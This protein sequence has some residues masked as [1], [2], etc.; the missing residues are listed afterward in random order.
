MTAAALP[1][2]GSFRRLTTT[3]SSRS[4]PR[5]RRR[6][7]RSGSSFGS[8]TSGPAGG[9]GAA[10]AAAA[11]GNWNCSRHW[12]QAMTAPGGTSVASNWNGQEGLGHLTMFITGH[13]GLCR[14]LYH[15]RPVRP[16]AHFSG[17]G[18]Y[19]RRG[20]PVHRYPPGGPDSL[21]PDRSAAY[22]WVAP[23]G[24]ENALTG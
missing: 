8:N 21:P 22:D 24:G 5:P 15:H 14:R 18:C 9:G 7:P 4:R 3:G 16:A 10:G 11:C 1:F 2:F 20:S 19:P 6:P 13:S 12:G 23:G 17:G